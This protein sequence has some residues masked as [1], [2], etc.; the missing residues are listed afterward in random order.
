MYYNI[1]VTMYD[2]SQNVLYLNLTNIIGGR[3]CQGVPHCTAL[4]TVGRGGGRRDVGV[5]GPL[6]LLAGQEVLAGVN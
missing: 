4:Q 3:H 2:L 1:D 5:Q 6:Q